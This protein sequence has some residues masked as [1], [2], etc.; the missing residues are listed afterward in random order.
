M[1]SQVRDESQ[2][3]HIRGINLLLLESSGRIAQ[4]SAVWKK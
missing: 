3:A 4:L 1:K 2:R